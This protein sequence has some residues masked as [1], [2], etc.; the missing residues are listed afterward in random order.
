MKTFTI[1]IQNAMTAHASDIWAG[2]GVVK[3]QMEQELAALAATWPG[4][5]LVGDLEQVKGSHA[6]Y[7]V[8]GPQDG[9]EPDLECDPGSRAGTCV[10]AQAE[11]A[12]AKKACV[13]RENIWGK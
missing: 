3:F 6:R 1:D 8:Q 7:E 4:S 2:E 12:V 9:G 13:E 5:R 11:D 10:L